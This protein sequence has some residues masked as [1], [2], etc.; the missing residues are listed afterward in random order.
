[1]YAAAMRKEGEEDASAIIQF[2]EELVGL[3]SSS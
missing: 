1:M 2:M 3:S